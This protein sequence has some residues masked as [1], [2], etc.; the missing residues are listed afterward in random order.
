[1]RAGEVRVVI[2]VRSAVFAPFTNLGLMVID[3]E[4]E[5]SYKQ[6]EGLRYSA[7]DVALARSKMEGIKIILGS[8]TPSME[9]FY[10]A[11]NGTFTYLEIKK[12]VEMRKM[13]EVEIVDMTKAEKQTFSFSN[14]LLDAL[15]DSIQKKQQSLI[16]LNRRGYSPFFICTDC[17]HTY[18]CPSCSI[19]L[20]YHKD[21]NT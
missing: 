17:G 16:M 7:R 20:I 11:Q 10:A 21:T 12:R 5:S 13:P 9:A 2:G 19:T 3:E 15:K 14:I 6:F 8:A 1:M 18:K 4:Q